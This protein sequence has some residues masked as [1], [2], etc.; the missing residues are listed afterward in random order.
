VDR[1]G[2]G[3]TAWEEYAYGTSDNR[4]G[5]RVELVPG[6][7]WPYEWA[8]DHAAAA[9]GAAVRVAG[10]G[11]LR[12]WTVPMQLTRRVVLPDGRVRSTWRPAVPPERAFFV[13]LVPGV[14]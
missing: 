6:A 8:V 1:D 13:P 12:G 3:L 11:D 14:P 10:S 5:D 9:D 7:G 2:D 4:A